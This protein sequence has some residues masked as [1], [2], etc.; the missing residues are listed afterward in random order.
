MESK[1]K[2]SS[3][4]ISLWHSHSVESVLSSLK[5]DLKTGLSSE[6]VQKRLE[7][8]GPNELMEQ[9]NKSVFKIFLKQFQSPLIYLL[10]VA[11]VIAFFLKEMSD[12]LVIL[13]VVFLNSIVGAI[14]EGKA[15]KSLESLRQLSKLMVKVLRDS[16]E[17]IIE[18]KN[19]VP[20]DVLHLGSGDAIGA[21][22]RVVVSKDFLVSEAALTGESIPVEKSDLEVATDTILPERKCMVYS[23]TFVHSGRGKVVVIATGETAEVGKIALLTSSEEEIRTPLEY[24]VA[25]FGRVIIYF[26]LMV[27]ILIVAAGTWR[28]LEL[29]Q[30]FM[31]GVSQIVSMIPEGL[32]MAITVAL[33]VGVRR[34]A[35]KKA[36][37]R[38]LSAVE[39]LGSTNVICSDKT[40][41]MTRNEMTVSEMILPMRGQFEKIDVTGVGYIPQGDFKMG[42]EVEFKESEIKI[43]NRLL[44][45]SV[46][47]NDSGLTK[48]KKNEWE[49]LGDPTEG[50]L[51]TLAG[52]KG[53]WKKELEEKY[54]RKD[55]VPFDS[56][57]K[58]MATEHEIDGKDVVFIKGAPERIR[59]FCRLLPE[60]ENIAEEM[61]S[62][63][64]RVLAFAEVSGKLTKE[65][66][67]GRFKEKATFLGFVGEMDPPREEVKLAVEECLNAGIRPVMITG[68]HKRTAQAI[69]TILGIARPSDEVVDGRELEAMSDQELENRIDRIAIFS[70][71]LPEQKM[72]IIQNLQKKNYVV[73]MTGDGVNDAP[74]LARADVGIAMGSTGTD[75]AK[76]AAKII[77]TDDNFATIVLAV[78]E[79]RLVYRNVKKLILYLFT[80][81][82]S[83]ILVLFT[84]L[85]FGYPPP[86]AAVQILWINLVTDGALTV[87]LIMEP[88]EGDEMKELP[89]SR[90]EPLINKE[91]AYRMA[92]ISPT[93]AIAT[94]GYYFFSLSQDKSFSQV[95]TETFTVLVVSQWFNVLN[96]RSKRQSVFKMGL[97]KNKWLVGGLLAGNILQ[98]S[99]IYIPFMNRIFHTTPIPLRD[100]IIIGLVGSSVLWVEEMRKMLKRCQVPI[101]Q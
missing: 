56:S 23:G 45:A 74:A 57:K 99:V 83:E 98:A 38:K 6:E 62:R 24:K 59:E 17:C 40:G 10:L 66:K 71:V 44:I 54:P 32:P 2:T 97:L 1:S 100:V 58:F 48:N 43:L 18:A 33:A 76:E 79:G 7:K 77:I 46:L 27:F 93:M 42:R 53:V 87:T 75:T 35:Q 25:Q 12:G 64:L 21:D 37:V 89:R 96:C 85:L 49:I 8:Y 55:E 15:E 30:I 31:I 80:T 34:M 101:W 78:K 95:Q 26:A 4:N 47:C 81:G 39:T 22:A 51:L 60:A 92:L 69:G 86:L 3:K 72:R 50:A 68:D 94:L 52:K 5:V 19:L 9:R 61:A 63:A 28:G 41:T 65:I 14:Q 70:R 36:I 73:A 13:V 91:M 82:L 11:S 67:S 16:E 90:N 20:G 29:S 84:A 88:E